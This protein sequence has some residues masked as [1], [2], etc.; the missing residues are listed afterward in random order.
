MLTFGVGATINQTSVHASDT[1]ADAATTSTVV[2]STTSDAAGNQVALKTSSSTGSEVSDQS[3]TGADNQS[4]SSSAGST[5]SPASSES[6]STTSS[7]ASQSSTVNNTT[8]T[9]N[10]ISARS[11][12]VASAD[13]DETDS[14]TK[15]VDPVNTGSL[16][17]TNPAG[18]DAATSVIDTSEEVSDS[19]ETTGS[20]VVGTDGKVTLTNGK[21]QNG[22]YVFDNQVD[23]TKGFTLTGS[24]SNGVTT[25]G[26]GLGIIIQP[27]DPQNAGNNSN[28][29]ADV[30]IDGLA[31]TT[32]IGRDFYNDALKGDTTWSALTIRQTDDSGNM[33]TTPAAN[34]T[35]GTGQ[36]NVIKAGEYYTL[37]WT[38]TSVDTTTGKVTGTL[39]YT[40]YTDSTKSTVLQATGPVTVVL[41]GAVSLAAFGAT[42][43]ATTSQTATIT[44][45]SGTRVTMPVVVHYVD[46]N[47]K[48]IS[49]DNT[50]TVNVGSTFG[51]GA[52]TDTENNTDTY[53]TYQAKKI[54]GY[55]FS[56]ATGPVTVINTNISTGSNDITVTYSVAQQTVNYTVPAARWYYCYSVSNTISCCRHNGSNCS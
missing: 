18:S 24:Y 38:P 4:A 11:A 12:V 43:G 42:G 45:F 7:A 13:A 28:S 31:D 22:S 40:T 3:T 34:V 25:T 51:V 19:F 14:D 46:Q 39:T 52:N 49:T 23:T 9:A 30:G 17:G 35:S 2:T 20:A 56:S 16:D 32:F 37:T 41:N 29:T 15:A 1:T 55:T 21:G 33:I 26:G 48:P 54:D 6:Q 36:T 5:S 44:S 47:G 27:V 8:S 10:K 53:G 50:I